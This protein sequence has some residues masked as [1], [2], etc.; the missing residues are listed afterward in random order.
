M[1][2]V[3]H[4]EAELKR[5]LALIL[6]EEDCG[7]PGWGRVEQMC[8]DLSKELSVDACGACP[9]HIYHF[10]ADCDIRQRNKEY[11]ETQRADVRTYLE[12][13]VSD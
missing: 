7:S 13:R 3:L 2:E 1:S 5:H 11:A 10:I 9:H 12:A 4:D 8:L 6:G